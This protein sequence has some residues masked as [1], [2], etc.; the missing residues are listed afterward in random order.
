LVQTAPDDAEVR[1]NLG[2]DLDTLGFCRHKLN[3]SKEAE[4]AFREAITHQSVA[5]QKSPQHF[6]WLC[7]HYQRLGSVLRDLNRPAD[8]MAVA[9]EWKQTKPDDA[10]TLFHVARELALCVP[11]FAKGATAPT[12]T[13]TSEGKRCADLALELLQGAGKRGLDLRQQLQNDPNFDS[14]RD[15]DEFKKLLAS[16]KS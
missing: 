11:V 2:R 5:L 3:K 12:S 4:S 9:L 15:R 8:A 14:I 10:M 7:Q 13:E 1:H 6:P 16:P